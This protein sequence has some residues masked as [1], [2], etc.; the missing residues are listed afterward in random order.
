MEAKDQR[1]R[2]HD[3][4]SFPQTYRSDTRPHAGSHTGLQDSRGAQAIG[5][6]RY[7]QSQ[8]LS[9]TRPAASNTIA[10]ADANALDSAHFGF[11]R[12]TQFAEPQAQS[13]AFQ[14]QPG[15]QLGHQRQ[16]SYSQYPSDMVYGIPQQVAQASAYD[17]VAQYQPRQTAAIEAMSNQF[18]VPQYY[19]PGDPLNATTPTGPS[20]Q[21]S[22]VPYQ[23]VMPYNAASDLERSMPTSS[24]TT[25]DLIVPAASSS[26]T[27]RPQQ[28][29]P[30]PHEIF[31]SRYRRALRETNENTLRGRLIQ[32]GESLLEISEWLLGSVEAL[33]KSIDACT[34]SILT[35]C[36]PNQG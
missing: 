24:R 15:H 9:T 12:A 32:A 36:R 2:H 10:S 1:R 13:N 3:Q 4:Q 21:Y 18:Q 20:P 26:G 19:V 33:G 30:D 27:S 23:H 5:A 34:R 35:V 7:L 6:N 22:G 14:Y 28:Q 29:S 17:A 11:E 16:G 8:A 31:Y 25:T